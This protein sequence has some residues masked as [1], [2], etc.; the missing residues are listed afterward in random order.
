MILLYELESKSHITKLS[1]L[2][3]VSVFPKPIERQKV[4][5]CLNVFSEK[6]RSAILH[7]PACQMLMEE[8][9]LQLLLNDLLL[10]FTI[11]NV[12]AQ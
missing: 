9:T 6:T 7:H 5:T 2:N 1:K 12:K 8:K 11:V 4:F 10:F 3:E